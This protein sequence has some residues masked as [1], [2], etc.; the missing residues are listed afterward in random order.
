MKLICFR[1]A[2]RTGIA[3][4]NRVDKHEIGNIEDRVHIWDHRLGWGKGFSAVL[5]SGDDFW[6]K[7]AEVKP[8]GR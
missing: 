7:S 1:I 3:G 4:G 2:R 5:G 8:D 6:P